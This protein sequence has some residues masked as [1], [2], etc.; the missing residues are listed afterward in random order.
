MNLLITQSNYIPWKGYFDNIAQADLF[1][2]YDDMQYTKRDWRNS[3]LIQTNTGKQWLTIPVEVKGKFSQKI[4]KT[5]IADNSWNAKHL[6]QLKNNYAKAACFKQMVEW[7]EDLYMT[8]KSSNLS[9]INLHFLQRICNF[10]EIETKII[11]SKDLSFTGDRTEKLINICTMLQADKYL[12]GPLAKNYI[13]EDAFFKKGIG[14]D[15]FE[16]GGYKE[17][18]QLYMPFDH[19]VTILDLIFNCGKEARKYLKCNNKT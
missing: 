18:H 4:N 16:Y 2:V 15:Y 13:D 12:T 9:D 14:I 1:V 7:I 6:T 10:L 8:A 5:T 3:N 19:H 11:D 17:Y